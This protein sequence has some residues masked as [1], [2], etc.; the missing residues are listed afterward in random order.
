MVLKKS[1]EESVEKAIGMFL[2]KWRE[3]KDIMGAER[4]FF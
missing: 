1:A 3:N 2:L 4:V